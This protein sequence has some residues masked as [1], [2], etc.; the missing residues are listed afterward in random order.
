MNAV[1]TQKLKQD[2]QVV[3]TDAEE[4][5]KATASQTGERIEKVRDR[6]EASLREARARLADASVAVAE[7]AR[8]AADS[9]DDQVHKHPYT[10]AGVAAGLGLLIGLLIGR[11]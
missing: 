1:L 7:R 3:V 5:L 6:M 11:R 4:L 10:A 9:V 8:V 2:L